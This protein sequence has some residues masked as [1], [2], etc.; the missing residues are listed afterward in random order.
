[1]SKTLGKIVG[2][3]DS[4]SNYRAF[5]KAIIPR[6][7]LKRGETFGAELLVLAKKQGLR[8]GEL[9]F[10]P[11]ARRKRPRIGGKLRANL[12][13]LWASMKAFEVYLF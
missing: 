8:I 3:G 13:I 9:R 2:V 7:N 6:L 1:M 11:P 12:R 4:F 10:V 5:R